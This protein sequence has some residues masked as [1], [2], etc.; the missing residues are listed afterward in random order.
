[1]INVHNRLAILFAVALSTATCTRTVPQGTQDN[2][3]EGGQAST[4]T[5]QGAQEQIT[6]TAHT[7]PFSSGP[8]RE[9]TVLVEGDFCP[10]VEQVC[11]RWVDNLGVK[12]PPPGP[13]TTGRCGEFRKPSRCLSA[14]VENKRFCIDVYEYPNVPGTV[15]QSWMSWESA[16]VEL[17][18]LG[19]RLCTKSEWTFACESPE[20]HPYPYGD[21][22]HR[23]RTA[24]NF[25]NPIP[26][27]L[28]TF[29][30]KSREDKTGTRLEALLVPSG[31]KERCVSPFGVRDLVGNI[32]EWVVNESGQ[33]HKSALVGGHVFGFRNA[34]RPMTDAHGEKFNWYETGTRGCSEVTQ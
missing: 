1:M 8:C 13:H 18:S 31:A 22:Y 14:A 16:S 26:K 3:G 15:P 4:T 20:I 27:N 7:A 33:P 10:R 28:D 23:D 6:V 9:G 2:A 29:A 5:V 12:S 32:D 19:K 17:Q 30:A 21:G 25:D 11:L 24:C 34:C